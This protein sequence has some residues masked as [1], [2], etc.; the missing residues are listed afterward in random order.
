MTP[1]KHPAEALATA[2]DAIGY[3]NA[4]SILAMNVIKQ[5]PAMLLT[6]PALESER[7]ALRQA[8][9]DIM[10]HSRDCHAQDMAQQALDAPQAVA[11]ALPAAPGAA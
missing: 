5:A 10:S 1:D 9:R 2:L 6:I 8:L 7:D 11:T 4:D 3:H